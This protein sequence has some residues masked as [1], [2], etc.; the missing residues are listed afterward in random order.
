LGGIFIVAFIVSCDLQYL[1]CEELNLSTQSFKDM[2]EC[3]L[4]LSQI[5]SEQ[6]QRLGTMR[7]VFGRCHYLMNETRKGN[8]KIAR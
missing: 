4:V 2:E 8:A 7:I 6:Q 3:H 1:I 5:V